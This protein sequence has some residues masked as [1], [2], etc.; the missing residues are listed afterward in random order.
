MRAVSL[1][2]M[3]LGG[4]NPLFFI[5]GPC[6]IEGAAHAL[7]H[8]K[9][10]AEIC[11]EAGVP[12]IYKSSFDK[13]NRTSSKSFRG[14]GMAK[15][16]EILAKVKEKAGVAVLTDVHS[17]EDARRAAKVV[18]ILQIPAFLCRQTDLIGAAAKTGRIVNVKKGQFLAP[19]DMKNVIAKAG[20]R[21]S[22]KV[23]V[24]ERGTSFGYNQLVVDMKA[25]P[26]MRAMGVPVVMD[27]GHS[28][29]QPGGLGETTGGMRE[30][31]PLM[32]KTGVAAGAD[33]LF[34]EVHEDPDHA[35]SDGPNMLKLADLPRLLRDVT[36]IRAAL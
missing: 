29:Q 33:G 21:S 10:M 13:A 8:A 17:P 26:I 34:V 30:M 1:N 7:R 32:A 14:P 27:A 6:V 5:G 4:K 2:G 19:W 25:I 22:G 28:V 31:I 3:K 35:P 12:F 15:G 24:T 23:M 18:D 36:A 11:R 9:A 20:G 16:L